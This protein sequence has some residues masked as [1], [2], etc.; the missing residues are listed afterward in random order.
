MALP[1][2]VRT[3]PDPKNAE[4]GPFIELEPPALADDGGQWRPVVQPSPWPRWRPL[5][6]AGVRHL[7]RRTL[8][9]TSGI[10]GVVAY[11]T[12]RWPTDSRTAGRPHEHLATPT[13][14]ARSP[15]RS[16]CQSAA[17]TTRCGRSV[18]STI[19]R[20]PTSAASTTSCTARSGSPTGLAPDQGRRR[21]APNRDSPERG[22]QQRLGLRRSQP[23]PRASR[24]G[25]DLPLG[26]PTP[27]QLA[28]RPEDPAL[29]RHA[30]SE[31]SLHPRVR[32][33]L[34]GRGRHAP[35]HIA[36]PPTP[37]CLSIGS[38]RCPVTAPKRGVSRP[39]AEGSPVDRDLCLPSRKKGPSALEGSSRQAKD[40]RRKGS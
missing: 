30:P 3:H 26:V 1:P 33:T 24:T 15:T 21:A 7:P 13:Y 14:P 10:L 22:R 12:T 4:G 9:A 8:D 37:A 11:D 39:M 32:R 27:G 2:A 17:T 28:E 38:H 31:P 6:S 19:A 18:A 20:S 34:Q 40:R 16:P 23:L 36:E 25:C 5:A 35:A 29:R